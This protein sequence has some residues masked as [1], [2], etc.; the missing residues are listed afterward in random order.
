MADGTVIPLV[1]MPNEYG[2][3]VYYSVHAQGEVC[4]SE[5][6]ID[7]ES[8]CLSSAEANKLFSLLAEQRTPQTFSDL[9]PGDHVKYHFEFENGNEAVLDCEIT[10]ISKTAVRGE[11][12]FDA[13]RNQWFR[14]L[15]GT[16][17]DGIE[18]GFITL[19]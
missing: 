16:S 14:K 17:M 5:S 10:A 8:I 15:D 6:G 4:L 1:D 3:V 9:M 19:N 12:F 18:Y 13:D 7:G 2:R 11:Y